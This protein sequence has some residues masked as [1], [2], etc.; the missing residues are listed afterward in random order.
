VTHKAEQ[1]LR[2]SQAL[3]FVPWLREYLQVLV[4]RARVR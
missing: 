1:D 4:S 3:T 2:A